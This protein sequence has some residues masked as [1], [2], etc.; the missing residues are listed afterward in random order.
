MKHSVKMKGDAIRG[1]ARISLPA[2][3]N[4]DSI[5]VAQQIV[6]FASCRSRATIPEI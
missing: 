2:N 1:Q 6:L 3:L 4:A 5:P